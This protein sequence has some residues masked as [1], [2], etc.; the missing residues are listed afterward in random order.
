MTQP[1]NLSTN[2][3]DICVRT[4]D[5]KI[6]TIQNFLYFSSIRTN[7][8]GQKNNI[9]SWTMSTTSKNS[10]QINFENNTWLIS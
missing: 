2:I 9:S 10:E 3:K 6:L 7:W 5:E 1:K 8:L 4:T